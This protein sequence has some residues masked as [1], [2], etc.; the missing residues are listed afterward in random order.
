MRGGIR[1]ASEVLSGNALEELPRRLSGLLGMQLPAMSPNPEEW[2]RP[3]FDLCH[4]RAALPVMTS[5]GC[6]YS[7]TYCASKKLWPRYVRRSVESVFEEMSEAAREWGTRDF[8]FY[9]DA[10]LVGAEQF[11]QPLLRRIAQAGLGVRLHVPNGMHYQLIDA[12]LAADMKSAGVETIRLSLESVEAERLR[13][14]NRAGDPEEFRRSVTALLGAGYERRQIGVYLM[15]GM[16]GQSVEEVSRAIEF[17]KASGAIP[18]LNEYSPIPGTGEWQEALRLSGRE[19]EE[20]PLWQ[21]NSLYYT[22]GE[23]GFTREDFQ[24]LKD[25]AKEI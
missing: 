1:G 10:L 14:W 17:V 7:C 21:N 23:T 4:S 13:S 22:R 2:P 24:R 11:A 12:A 19:I 16:P 5:L 15:A 20:E 9:D 6:P 18:K 25:L 3:A 8:A